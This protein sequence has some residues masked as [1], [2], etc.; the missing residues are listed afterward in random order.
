MVRNYTRKNV[1]K[2]SPQDMEAAIKAVTE[3][4]VTLRVAALEF[5]VPRSTLSDHIQGK[6][7]KAHGHATILK[8]EEEKRIVQCLTY[9]SIC[10]WPM[11]RIDVASMVN[12]YCIAADKKVPW[13]TK[14]G[15]GIDFLQ[16]FEKRWQHKLTKRKTENLTTSRAKS[17]SSETISSFFTM[18]GR[19]YDKYDLSDKPASI[20]NLDE[21]GLNTNQSGTPCYFRRGCKD[22]SILSPSSGKAVYTILVC[23]NSDGSHLLPPFVCYKAKFLHSNW[24]TGGPDSPVKCSASLNQIKVGSWVVTKLMAETRRRNRIAQQP[25]LYIGKVSQMFHKIRL[26]MVRFRT[27]SVQLHNKRNKLAFK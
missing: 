16:L 9:A 21:T 23:G 2:Y 7:L 8:F 14:K 15:P 5:N 12:R 27:Y 26:N 6:H 18:L 4:G 17:L 11:D 22:V 19:I 10:G 13:D 25:R 3:E 1:K 24:C 20:Y